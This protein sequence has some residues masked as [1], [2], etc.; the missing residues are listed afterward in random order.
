VKRNL[1]ATGF[2][3]AGLTALALAFLGRGRT[4]SL[5]AAV[6]FLFLAGTLLSS[7]RRV[8]TLLREFVGK[9]VVVTVWGAP[10]T[11]EAPALVMTSVSSLGA[12]LLIRLQH[13]TKP[14]LLKVAQ[15]KRA[16]FEGGRLVV[17]EAAYVQWAGRRLARQPGHDAVLLRVVE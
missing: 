1:A 12:G 6:L 10:L 17:P 13:G 4:V 5:A 7:A 2:A 11:A 16:A 3:I 8:S 14:Q 9:R 15:P